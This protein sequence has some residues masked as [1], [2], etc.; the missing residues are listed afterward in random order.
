MKTAPGLLLLLTLLAPGAARAED[1][2]PR[3]VEIVVEGAYVPS[4]IDAREGERLRLRFV[5]KSW[6]PCVREVIFPALGIR[7]TLPPGETTEIELPPL[8][9]GEVE[10]HCGMKMVRGRIRV[11]RAGS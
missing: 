6:S 11:A 5:Q 9:P 8:P 2:P 4:L 7:R 10:F 3:T 1:P